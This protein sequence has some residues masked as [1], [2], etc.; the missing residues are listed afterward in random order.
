MGLVCRNVAFYSLAWIL[1]QT[2]TNLTEVYHGFSA[3]WRDVLDP[4][5]QAGRED[6]IGHISPPPEN[7]KI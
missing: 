2:P 3:K 7:I 6:Q 4:W 1:I 5:A